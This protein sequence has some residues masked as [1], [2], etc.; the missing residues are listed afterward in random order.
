VLPEHQGAGLGG[1][2]VARLLADI[3]RR[4]PPQ[5]FVGLFASA[6]KEPFYQRYAFQTHPAL[7]G[8][9]QVTPLGER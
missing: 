2:I 1:L 4:A 9:F 6:G 5:A 3:V 7:T 8:M